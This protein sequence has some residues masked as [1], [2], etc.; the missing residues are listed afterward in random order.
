MQA[1]ARGTRVCVCVCM[2]VCM[3]D[4]EQPMARADLMSSSSLSCLEVVSGDSSVGGDGPIQ[5]QK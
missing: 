5:V 2:C 1:L 3:C 4:D